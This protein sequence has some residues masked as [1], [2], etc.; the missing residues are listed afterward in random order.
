MTR[1]Q[2]SVGLTFYAQMCGPAEQA[3]IKAEPGMPS[4]L[5]SFTATSSSPPTIS[6][7]E[8]AIISTSPSASLATFAPPTTAYPS[9][10]SPIPIN[11]SL[12]LP[13]TLQHSGLVLP[14]HPLPPGLPRSPLLSISEVTADHNIVHKQKVKTFLGDQYSAGPQL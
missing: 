13:S 6:L 8:A 7:Q 3:I 9:I 2:D 11:I 4:S 5:L 12:S 14:I 1:I 10:P